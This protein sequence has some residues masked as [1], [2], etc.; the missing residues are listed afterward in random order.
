VVHLVFQ[1]VLIGDRHNLLISIPEAVLVCLLEWNVM[2]PT[3][4]GV[5]FWIL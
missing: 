3:Y 2:V 4:T 5:P 1:V